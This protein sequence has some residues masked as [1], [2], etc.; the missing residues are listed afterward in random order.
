M[1]RACLVDYFFIGDR[2]VDSAVDVQ[3]FVGRNWDSS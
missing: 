1:A 3:H 2:A